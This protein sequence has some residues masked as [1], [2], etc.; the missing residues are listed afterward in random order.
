MS[1]SYTV[2]VDGASSD[3]IL[4]RPLCLIDKRCQ[5]ILGDPKS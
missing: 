2:G 5:A 3:L 1:F 4:G